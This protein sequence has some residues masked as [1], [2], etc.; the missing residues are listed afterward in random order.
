[1]KP[2]MT[3]AAT[4]AESLRRSLGLPADNL[5]RLV[6]EVAREL[7]CRAYLVG[8]IVRDLVV[9]YPN[10]DFDVVVEGRAEEVARRF[11][12]RLGTRARKHTEFGTCKV[13]TRELGTVDFATSRTETYR[14][15]GA[16][17]EIVAAGIAGDLE[18]RDFTV[19][20]MAIRLGP[21]EYG[22]LLDPCDGLGDLR[23][24]RLR[25]M[26]DASFRDDPTR[27]LRGVRFA[28]R[29][30][31]AFDHHTLSLLRE[32]LAGGGLDTISGKRIYTELRL[33]SME[34]SAAKALR[35]LDRLGVV[36]KTVPGGRR[37]R[38]RELWRAL[39]RSLA[40]VAS[41]AGED[42]ARPWVSWL[43][44]L[45]VGAGAAKAAV[46]VGT[47][48]PPRDVRDACGWAAGELD[49]V[50]AALE[51]G[52][53]GPERAVRILDGVPAEGMALLR[54]VGSRRVKRL[55]TIYLRRWRHVEATV[56]GGAV[57]ALGLG[58]GPHVGMILAEIK[59]L[60]LSGKLPTREDELAYARRRVAALARRRAKSR[61]RGGTLAGD[62]C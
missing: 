33:I 15:P 20:A 24:G 54:A 58:P 22:G 45:L 31:L 9:G 55:V 44:S 18:R 59:R 3:P 25:V 17:P 8:G 16:L 49:R 26:H 10:T 2:D 41:A 52:G 48:N 35:M 29:Y 43:A 42:Y 4:S 46:T 40:Q 23:R 12:A 53:P 37:D 50:V 51:R 39:P 34:A 47:L 30:G 36:E 6:G 7:G 21:G 57:A 27:I 32:C 1:M 60:R 62:R 14:R 61:G 19:N 13:D 38:R 56:S 11:A 5:L 28:S